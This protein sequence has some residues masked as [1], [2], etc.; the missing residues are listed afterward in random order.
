MGNRQHGRTGKPHVKIIFSDATC[1]R[2]MWKKPPAQA[3]SSSD[4][5]GSLVKKAL[6]RQKG[7]FISGITTILL[8]K[9]TLVFNRSI[10]KSADETLCLSI[11]STT[12]TLD[13]RAYS[14]EDYELLSC[15]LSLLV[16]L[17]GAGRHRD[18]RAK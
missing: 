16:K 3:L 11:V 15:G 9:Q 6:F 14:F 1:S 12:R 17:H 8:G 5:N 18:P 7:I 2:L 4:P 10:A 13:I